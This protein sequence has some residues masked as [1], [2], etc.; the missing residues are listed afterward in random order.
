MRF[1]FVSSEFVFI[2]LRDLLNPIPLIHGQPNFV[3]DP[4]TSQGPLLIPGVA[5]FKSI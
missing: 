1:G 2:H 4:R 3:H 5:A